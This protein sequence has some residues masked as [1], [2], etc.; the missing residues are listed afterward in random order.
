MTQ[1]RMEPLADPSAL[2]PANR[3]GG[4]YEPVSILGVGA[5]S[6]VYLAKDTMLAGEPVALKLLHASMPEGS[7]ARQRFVKEGRILLGLSHPHIVRSYGIGIHLDDD[8]QRPFLVL[9][10]IHGLALDRYCA[11]TPPSTG[12]ALRLLRELAS[13]LD[14]LHRK[15]LVHRDLKPSNIMVT[16]TGSLVLLDLGIVREDEPGTAHGGTTMLGTPLWMSPEQ[17]RG[18]AVGARS[19][20]YS[21]G[22]VAIGLLSSLPDGFPPAIA[23][24]DAARERALERRISKLEVS[25]A[26][27]DALRSCIA[28]EAEHRPLSIAL[29]R[30]LL[31]EEHGAR[32]RTLERAAGR[33]LGIAL[34]LVLM[35]ALLLGGYLGTLH[36]VRASSFSAFHYPLLRAVALQ[37]YSPVR[38]FLPTRSGRLWW[39]LA[40]DPDQTLIASIRAG[41]QEIYEWLLGPADAQPSS[42]FE[43]D[44]PLLAAISVG[45]YELVRRLLDDFRVPPAPLRETTPLREALRVNRLDIAHLILDKLAVNP[46]PFPRPLE[47]QLESISLA[48]FPTFKRL[49]ELGLITKAPPNDPSPYRFVQHASGSRD[50]AEK[51]GLMFDRGLIAVDGADSTGFYWA[52][53]FF[54][55]GFGKEFEFFL[56]SGFDVNRTCRDDTALRT[57]LRQQ[58]TS[59]ARINALLRKYPFDLKYTVNGLQPLHWAIYVLRPRVIEQLLA[60]GSD[61]NALTTDGRSALQFALNHAGP[62]KSL[63]KYCPKFFSYDECRT[64]EPTLKSRAR[65]ARI[66]AILLRAGADPRVPRDLTP[67][68]R[69]LARE[70][71][72]HPLTA[73]LDAWE[74]KVGWSGSLSETIAAGGTA[75]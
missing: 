7:A 73:A 4:R 14:E 72:F 63:T 29:V 45:N 9:E 2:L 59:S 62:R 20:I 60:L 44:S 5:T 48:D 22:L 3:I 11:A 19:D 27:R 40:A 52:F 38:V 16:E 51:L 24:D 36:L 33:V 70:T 43:N 71:E 42:T 57:M 55:S 30:P 21:F 46:S 61:P 66:A 35:V 25:A 65:I 17:R 53:H 50:D 56:R 18:G 49:V 1:V 34:L 75:P 10:H 54:N 31:D 39:A 32:P 47:E 64:D 67:R 37:R 8:Q 68:L 69:E 13:A 41:D 26:L 74:A 58:Y 6:I 28:S 12:T 15:G 23:Q